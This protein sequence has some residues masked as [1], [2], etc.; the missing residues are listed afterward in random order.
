VAAPVRVSAR[1][2]IGVDHHRCGQLGKQDHR[3]VAVSLSVANKSASLAIAWPPY[4][5]EIGLDKAE[6]HQ[7]AKIPNALPRPLTPCPCRIRINVLFMTPQEAGPPDPAALTK[8]VQ[9]VRV[10]LAASFTSVDF[11][12]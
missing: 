5:P 9:V 8:I 7:K 12:I 1:H 10:A 6:R 3:Q 2:S 11:S 4:L